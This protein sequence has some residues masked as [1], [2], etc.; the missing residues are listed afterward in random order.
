MINKNQ[1]RKWAYQQRS[2]QKNKE[3]VSNRICTAFIG[4]AEYQ[5]AKTVMWYVD[6]RSEVRT[7]TNLKQQLQTT[8]KIVVPFCTQDEKGNNQLGLWHLES[9]DELEPGTW[10]ILEPPK[11]RWNEKNKRLETKELDVIMVPGVAFDKQ[12]GRLGNGGGYYDR[13]L[14]QVRADTALHAVCFECQL[15]PEI[16]MDEHDIYMNK[17]ITEKDVYTGKGR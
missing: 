7:L 1:Q 8:K 12:G 6:C 10:G 3:V 5:A 14:Q 17:I 11:S 16:I 9:M 15:L 2:Q 13:L 4:L